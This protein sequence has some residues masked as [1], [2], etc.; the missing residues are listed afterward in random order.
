MVYIILIKNIVDNKA[1]LHSL[2]KD[3]ND[4]NCLSITSSNYTIVEES[5]ENFNAVKNGTKYPATY[6]KGVISY[7]D[8]TSY[9]HNK[10]DLQNYI[11]QFKKK[12]KTFTD[13]DLN[14]TK[15]CWN[16]WE[17][18]YNQLEELN[19]QLN[20]LEFLKDDFPMEKSLQQYF[21]DLGKISLSPL[22]I[23]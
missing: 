17:D 21:D 8:V 4:L 19:V 16:M 11:N 13:N 5:E 22:Q 12:I 14:K 7:D 9:F 23:P 2:A 1:Y 3:Q 20:D 10:E 6:N 15:T 18:Y